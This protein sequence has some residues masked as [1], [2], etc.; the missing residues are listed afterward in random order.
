MADKK[1]PKNEFFFSFWQKKSKNK[2]VNTFVRQLVAIYVYNMSFNFHKSRF[3]GFEDI[4]ET[5]RKNFVSR[6][7]RLKFF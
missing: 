5:V 3:T 2:N 4:V 1:K 6:K 7:T